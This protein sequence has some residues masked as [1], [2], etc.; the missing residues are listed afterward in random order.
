MMYLQQQTLGLRNCKLAAN[1]ELIC[2]LKTAGKC[3]APF[4]CN[5][6]SNLKQDI[7]MAY[8]NEYNATSNVLFYKTYMAPRHL[9]GYPKAWEG[10]I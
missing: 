7:D 10:N 4:V 1:S 5:W 3:H 2:G 9:I 8:T 6:H